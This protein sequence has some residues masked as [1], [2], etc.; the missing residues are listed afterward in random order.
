MKYCTECGRATSNT[1]KICRVCG[2]TSFEFHCPNCGEIY[3]NA[4]FCPNCGAPSGKARSVCP[5]CGAI[6]YGK[7]CKN[8]GNAITSARKTK[9]R[10][11]KRLF[12]LIVFLF[13]GLVLAGCIAFII[14]R[15]YMYPRTDLTASGFFSTFQKYKPPQKS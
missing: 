11:R 12:R 6:C 9:K 3:E 15:N 2:S 10:K 13:L 8:C 4:P 5:R 7:T 14:L 1:E